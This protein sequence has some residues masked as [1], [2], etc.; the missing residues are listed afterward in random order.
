MT[1]LTKLI[2]FWVLFCNFN[3][4]CMR[5]SLLA[6]KTFAENQNKMY[7]K[8]FEEKDGI[9]YKINYKPRVPKEKKD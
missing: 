1:F 6:A 2:F 9:L 7:E 5:A 3:I 4:E 8:H